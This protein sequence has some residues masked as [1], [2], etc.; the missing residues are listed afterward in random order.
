MRTLFATCAATKSEDIE[1]CSWTGSTLKIGSDSS[2]SCMV[3]FDRDD[4][5]DAD[6]LYWVTEAPSGTYVLLPGQHGAL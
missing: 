5:A 1:N 2:I 6:A 4:A 3:K